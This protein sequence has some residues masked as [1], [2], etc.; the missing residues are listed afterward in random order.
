MSTKGTLTRDQAIKLVGLET[1][2]RVEAENCEPTGRC[3]YNG[4]LQGDALTEWSAGVDCEDND[5]DSYVLLAY[6]YTTN[7]QDRA[8]ADADGDGSVIS[9]EITGYEIH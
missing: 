4:G 8:I 2:K 3:G 7:D 6:Y 9:W 1:V 5:L